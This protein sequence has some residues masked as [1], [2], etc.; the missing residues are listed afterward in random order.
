MSGCF[1]KES[2]LDVFARLLHVSRA[3]RKDGWV[4]RLSQTPTGSKKFDPLE[5]AV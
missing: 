2:P 1:T 5:N 3:S 4:C